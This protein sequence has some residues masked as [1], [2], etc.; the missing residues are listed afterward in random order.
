MDSGSPGA[1][2][3]GATCTKAA[4]CMS[5]LCEPF[6]QQTIMLCTKSCTAAT[7]ATDCPNPPSAGTCTPKMYC[8]FN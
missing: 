2:Q 4:D 5:G 1:G 6:R 7:Q 3:F 8:R